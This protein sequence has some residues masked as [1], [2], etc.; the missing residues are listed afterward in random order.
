LK[1]QFLLA[2]I[3][4]S[5]GWRR[6]LNALLGLGRTAA[7]F[8]L[9][10]CSIVSRFLTKLLQEL[11]QCNRVSSSGVHVCSDTLLEEAKLA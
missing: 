6:I 3:L 2:A 4:S 7:A 10:I 1:G 9:D 11:D 8:E 5:I